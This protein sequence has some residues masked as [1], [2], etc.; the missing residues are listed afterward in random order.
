MKRLIQ[1]LLPILCPLLLI[2]CKKEDVKPDAINPSAVNFTAN[3]DTQFENTIYPSLVLSLTNYSVKSGENFDFI[4][5]EVTNPKE[6]STVKIVLEEST[7]NNQTTLSEQLTEKGKKYSFVPQISWKYDA[8]KKA[9]QPGNISLNL[10]CYID[11]EEIQ[12]KT[13]TLSYRSVNECVFAIITPQ[14]AIPLHFLFGAYV[15]EDHPLVDKLLGDVLKEGVVSNFKGY[16][17]TE[18]DVVEE[19][20]AI[21][22]YLQKKGVKYSNI[23]AT[24]NPSTKIFTQYVRFFD[25]V[26]NT[27]QANCVDGT[28]FFASILKKI[29][30]NPLLVLEPNHMYLGFFAK[31]NNNALYTIETTAIGSVNLG[32]YSTSA[33]KIFYSWQSFSGAISTAGQKFNS[34]IEKMSDPE[35]MAYKAFDVQSLRTIVQPIS[36]RKIVN[37][38][39]IQIPE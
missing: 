10:K 31:A 36:T 37:R 25:Q 5:V 15:N 34:N 21:W 26:Y 2:N 17:G 3:F 6:T 7:F 8:L 9:S 13:L 12:Q 19:V 24:S 35:N 27:D 4:T 23:T 28:V 32:N 29:G 1:I 14:K 38:R 39:F 20:F 18:D 11:G 16:Q 30:I 22:Y 33:N